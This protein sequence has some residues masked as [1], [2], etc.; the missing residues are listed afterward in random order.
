[1]S[2]IIQKLIRL[3][4]GLFLY[5]IGIVL[6]INAN[7]G[8][9]PWDVFHQGITFLFGITMGQATIAVG[10]LIIIISSVLGERLG[11]GTL[12]N[13]FFI[14]YFMD[15]IMLNHLIPISNNAV[16]GLMMMF[17]GMIIIGIASYFYIGAG[18]GSG[19]RDGLMIALTK[20][21]HKSVRFIRNSLEINALLIGYLLGGYAGLGTLIM[22]IALG[23]IMQFEFKLLKFDINSIQHR[24]IDDDVRLLREKLYNKGET[25]GR[26]F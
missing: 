5:A 22:S 24:F 19:P 1:M 2:R 23:Y 11:W 18:I 12:F 20:K 14:G 21:T 9:S 4:M 17:L 25:R 26:S 15:L 6:T 10:I 3:F 16:S 8:L 13:M 7:L